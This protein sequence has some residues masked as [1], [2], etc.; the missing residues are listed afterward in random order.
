M[1]EKL[2]TIPL[3]DA[4]NENDEC[5]FC[6]IER[7]LEQ[8]AIDFTIGSGSSYMESDI[9]EQT[10][11]IGFCRDHLKKMYDYGN[12]LGNALIMKTHYQ[13]IMKE[14]HEQFG[15]YTPG[16]TQKINL[17]HRKGQDG[18]ENKNPIQSWT[19]SK[20]CS[21]YICQTVQPTF[22]RYIETFFYLYRQD[23]AFKA[24]ILNGKGF[25]LHHFGT[26]CQNA[27]HY[28]NEKER[29]EFYPAMFGVMEKNFARIEEDISWLVDKFD[30]RNRDA[31][32]KN[33]Q[34]AL[35]RGMQKL[36]GGYPIDPPYKAK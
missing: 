35:T 3:N 2:Y 36:R 5:P 14:M 26:L 20:D 4:V 15:S 11:K 31:D 28:L 13:R 21:C 32:W 25:C 6:F 30:Y 10:D 27:D 29:A 8:D 33:S 9:R 1:K 34:D 22:E 17:F 16:K 24:K 7:K 19:E 18:S 12:T 23:E